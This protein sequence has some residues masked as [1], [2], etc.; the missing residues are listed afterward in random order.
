MPRAAHTHTVNLFFY[1]R[2]WCADK[3]TNLFTIRLRVGGSSCDINFW[4]FISNKTAQKVP[5]FSYPRS[6]RSN[7]YINRYRFSLNCWWWWCCYYCWLRVQWVLC[8]RLSLYLLPVAIFFCAHMVVVILKLALKW[9][10]NKM[11]FIICAKVDWNIVVHCM[12]T[13]MA[14]RYAVFMIV[15]FP[16]QF[17]E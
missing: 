12:Y 16:W 8:T 2:L 1:S 14:V 3:T 9:R 6:L 7:I 11:Y 15:I 13:G 17:H 10:A 4:N 5:F